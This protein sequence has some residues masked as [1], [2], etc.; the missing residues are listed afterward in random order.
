MSADDLRN[1]KNT[2]DNTL[3]LKQKIVS[4]Y[5][6]IKDLG[7]MDDILEQ[8][9]LNAQSFDTFEEIYAPYKPV[10]GEASI[11]GQIHTAL[12]EPANAIL[13]GKSVNFASYIDSA[14]TLDD[15][16]SVRKHIIA[17]VAKKIST[18]RPCLEYIQKLKKESRCTLQT[19]KINKRNT[20]TKENKDKTSGKAKMNKEAS[21][22]ADYFDRSFLTDR[23]KP[24]Q[25]MAINRAEH[26]KYINVTLS[27]NDFSKNFCYEM[28]KHFEEASRGLSS[29]L[30]ESAMLEC[31]NNIV[32]PLLKRIKRTELKSYAEKSSL[33]I[34]NNNLKQMLLAAPTKHKTILG[35][36]PGFTHGCKLGMISQNGDVLATK[37]VY[38][39]NTKKKE[40]QEEIFRDLMLEHECSLIALGNGT[41]CRET[42]SWIT[43][44]I[45][46]GIFTPL[47]VSYTIVNESGASIYSCSKEATK[48]FQNLDPNLISAVSLA[49]RIQDPLSELVKVEPKHLGI[50]MYQHDV[51]QKRLEEVLADVVSECV[52]FVGVDVNT[53]SQ[54]LLKHVA[55]LSDR[56]ADEII[57]QRPFC[58]RDQL[59]TVKGVGPL[60]YKQCAGFLKIINGNNKLDAT[61]IHPESYHIAKMIIKRL[62]LQMNQIGTDEFIKKIK[63]EESALLSDF[64]AF[65]T[66]LENL[67]L[68]LEGLSKPLEYDLR[69]DG[70]SRPLFRQG[71]TN[72]A[73][74]SVGMALTGAVNNCTSFGYFVDIGVGVNGLLHVKQARGVSLHV[75]DRVEVKISNI[76]LERKR[77]GLELVLKL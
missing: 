52:S 42:E 53:A 23:L 28:R 55:G 14:K 56:R 32:V 70:A 12:D 30:F 61:I 59:L 39:H 74:L 45:S 25:I 29:S 3:D 31:C 73:T 67:Q 60:T 46:R 35:V 9:L 64:A 65:E 71:V 2:Y 57:A 72:M 47:Q 51:N 62:K 13:K 26:L 38:P 43:D 7:K 15:V 40:V 36:D 33:D 19:K 17:V 21:N 41:A 16:N 68:V 76:E 24:H 18:S 50:G 4:A 27:F 5:N 22:F 6:K 48:E 54:C 37:V 34:F 8:T 77:I 1:V 20:T 66:S 10:A 44:M 11:K 49:R 58:T 69:E 63:S 75:G